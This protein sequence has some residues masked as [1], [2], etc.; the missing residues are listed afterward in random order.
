MEKA[1]DWTD[2]LCAEVH[3]RLTACT[4]R[5]DDIGPLTVAKWRWMKENGKD[6]EGFTEENALICILELL[7]CNGRFFDLTEGEYRSL[8]HECSLCNV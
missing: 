5:R 3:S 7:D 1:K 6:K 4:S 8:I 2:Y